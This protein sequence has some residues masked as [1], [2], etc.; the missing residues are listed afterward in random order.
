MSI[1]PLV[2]LPWL[3]TLVNEY[4]EQ[5]RDAAGES[6]QPYPDLTGRE[7]P[8]AASEVGATSLAAIAGRLWPVFAGTGT[9]GKAAAL[10]RLLR[11]ADLTPGVTPD[12]HPSWT[13]GHRAAAQVLTAGC[14]V[15]L[16]GAVESIGWQRLGICAGSDCADVYIDRYGRTPRRYCSATCL[17]RARV[18]AYRKRRKPQEPGITG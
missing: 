15:A 16:L 18:R 8:T 2:P 6:G 3:V 13:T 5:P 4:A 1:V 17:N 10:N 12:G 14:A 7:Q 11:D 9:G